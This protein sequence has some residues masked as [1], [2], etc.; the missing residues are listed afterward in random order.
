MDGRL[1]ESKD[2]F[3]SVL[4]ATT[5]KRDA[6][7]YIARFK[8]SAAGIEGRGPSRDKPL[9]FVETIRVA[10]IKIRAPQTLEDAIIQGLAH[11]LSQ[12][13]RLGLRCVLVL[14][15]EEELESVPLTTWRD[16]VTREADR[17]VAALDREAN[18]KA[19][20]LDYALGVSNNRHE[21]EG[22][23]EPGPDLYLQYPDLMLGMLEKGTIPVIPA[24]GYTSDSQQAIPISPDNVML[25]LSQQFTKTS[26]KR[27]LQDK[28]TDQSSVTV[29]RVILLDPLGGLPSAVRQD[30][31]HIFVNLAQEYD[32]VRQELLS[33]NTE[34][35]VH[36]AALQQKDPKGNFSLFGASNPFTR[37]L[38]TERPLRIPK[39][40]GANEASSVA[41]VTNRN[42]RNLD[43]LHQ[44]L[45]LLPPSSSALLTTPLEAATLSTEATELGVI[46]RRPKNPLIFN[47]LTDKPFVS[48]SL[49]ESR[50]ASSVDS[51]RSK[52]SQPNTATFFKVGL[53][54]AIT[55]DP[56]V[57]IWRAPSADNPP[58]SLENIGIDLPRLVHLIEDSFGRPLHTEHYLNRIREK[59]AGVIIAGDYEGGAI[60]TWELPPGTPDDGSVE[61]RQR[62][63]PY[64]DKFAVLK[65]SQGSGGVADIVF[66]AMVRSCFPHGVCWRSRKDNPV[67]KWYFERSIGTWKLTDSNWTMFWTTKHLFD[68]EQRFHDYESV[69]RS[70]QP[71]WADKRKVVD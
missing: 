36:S 45:K 34:Q 71:S 60:L 50:V 59:L 26:R 67:N 24:I 1:T 12:L 13:A 18:I 11:T 23:A 28:S 54:L 38:E 70:V 32:D 41:P 42:V 69:C 29:E 2:L 43:L 21:H 64:L 8:P 48:S 55:P 5:T 6:R 52:A 10:L 58:L 68:D 4:S 15:C 47:L 27:Q 39:P 51:P 53:P 40:Q 66:S 49:P 25:A 9:P 61:S 17:V 31:A 44:T 37:F 3:L 63:V 30:K 7:S 33:A 14:D 65:R 57:N 62:M 20:R 35:A 56:R 46:T 22:F 16:D 19:R